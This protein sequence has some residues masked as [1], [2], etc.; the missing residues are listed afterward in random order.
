MQKPTRENG[1]YQVR[2]KNGRIVAV[3]RHIEQAEPLKNQGRGR[4][5]WQWDGKRYF[6]K[7]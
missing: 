6:A 4:V 5:L 3:C 7:L 1:H 2:T